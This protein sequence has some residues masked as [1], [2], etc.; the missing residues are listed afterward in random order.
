M[1]TPAESS[2]SNSGTHFDRIAQSYDNHRKPGGPHNPVLKDLAS[3]A[4]AK[5]ILELGC[6]TGNST[7]SFTQSWPSTPFA[8]DLSANMLSQA[9]AKEIDAHWIN[10]NAD[11]IPLPDN[12]VDFIYSVLAFHLIKDAQTVLHE[13]YRVLNKG[14]C[15]IATSPAHFIRNHPLNHYF[16]SF[17]KIDSARFQSEQFLQLFMQDAGFNNTQITLCFDKPRPI[18]AAYVE[19]IENKFISTIALLPEDEF[20]QGLQ[21]LKQDIAETGQLKDPFIWQCVVVSGHKE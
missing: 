7:T 4:N 5:T 21:R 3:K 2:G 1:N 17:T 10:A 16:P 9:S 19:R 13:C 6:G 15:A 14:I 12:S 18:D 11:S 8:L 20:Q